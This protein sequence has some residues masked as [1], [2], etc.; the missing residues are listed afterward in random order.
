MLFINNKSIEAL[1]Y[2]MHI[3]LI[4]SITVKNYTIFFYRT[5]DKLSTVGGMI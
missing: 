1:L 4:K 2:D 3:F 5:D